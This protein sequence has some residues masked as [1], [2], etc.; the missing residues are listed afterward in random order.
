MSN[1]SEAEKLPEVEVQEE[2]QTTPAQLKVVKENKTGNDIKRCTH[3]K[4]KN[5]VN[6]PFADSPLIQQMAKQGKKGET[7]EP[8]AIQQSPIVENAEEITSQKEP[9]KELTPVQKIL[10]MIDKT[11]DIKT[12]KYIAY[13]CNKAGF[14][15]KEKYGEDS[16]W[17]L[18]PT[19]KE[20]ST[21]IVQAIM[22]KKFEI[23]IDEIGD[24][25][26]AFETLAFDCHETGLIRKI[27]T[28]RFGWKVEAV[29]GFR[30][31]MEIVKRIVAKKKEFKM[32]R[33]AK[34]N[35]NSEKAGM[36]SLMATY[37]EM[38]KVESAKK[39][40]KGKRNKKAKKEKG[41]GRK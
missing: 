25:E 41:K 12:L 39:H 19:E 15:R 17:R 21:E 23:L 36:N 13:D 22:A 8:T 11:A 27:N 31:S 7:K 40:R 16:K 26:R 18:T 29:K 20:G 35:K 1:G 32:K 33:E 3:R 30:N 34:K 24:D 10:E 6:M 9:E 4:V 28:S 2:V 38:Q 5:L 37:E 14:A